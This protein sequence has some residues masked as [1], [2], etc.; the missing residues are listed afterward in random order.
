MRYFY[1]VLIVLCVLLLLAGL[2]YLF[3]RLRMHHAACRVKK[4]SCCEKIEK[5]NRALSAFGFCYDE[6]NDAISSVRHPWQREMGYC[7]AYDEAAFS[8][9]MIID[10]EPVYFNY[11]GSRYLLELWKGQYGCTTGAE[12]GLYVNRSADPAKQPEDLFYESVGDEECLGM[13]FDLYKNGERILRRKGIHWWLTGF[14]VGMCSDREEL[15]LEVGL[16]FP[17]GAMRAAFC[18]GLLR[19]GYAAKDIRVE[20][21]TVRFRFNN[22]YSPQPNACG[23]WCRRRVMRRNLRNCRLYCKVT[24][25][26]CSTLDK[27]TYIG[28]CFP[29][30]YRTIIRIGTKCTEKKL[31]KCRRKYWR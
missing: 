14:C 9:Y 15:S 31:R 16:T 24:S 26:F 18:E 19:A 27:I 8:M 2:I 25:A 11:N 21:C 5:L 28:F 20:Q 1:C 12:I 6:E 29:L 13:Y 30:L 22:P 4:Y 3:V 17:N 10:C 23:R 7:S